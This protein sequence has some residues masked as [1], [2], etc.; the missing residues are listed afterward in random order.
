MKQTDGTFHSADGLTGATGSVPAAKLRRAGLTLTAVLGSLL[1]I[2]VSRTTWRRVE[3]LQG[4]FGGLKADNFYLGVRVRGDIQ[5]LNDTLLRYR[6]RGDTN[7]AAAFRADAQVFKQW[8]EQNRAN[9][10]TPVERKFFDQVTGAYDDYL[11]ESTQV[12]EAS[13]GRMESTKAR[14]FTKSYEKVRNESRGLLNLCDSF[15]GNQRSS[16]TGFLKESSATLTDFKVLLRLLLVLVLA[17]VAALVVLVYGGMIAPLRHQLAETHALIARQEKLASLGVLAAGV[18]HEIRNPLTAIKLRL[19]SLKQHL[20]GAGADDEDAGVI[21]NEITRLERIVQDFL[22]FARPS[23]PQLVATPVQRLFEEVRSLLGVPLKN[24]A[25]ELKVEPAKAAWVRADPQQL[26]QVLINLVQNSADSI[27]RNGVITLRVRNGSGS[28]R[29][30]R[31]QAVILEVADNGK[32]IPPE[33]RKRLFDPFFTTK[34]SGTGLGLPI[35]A[36]IIGKHGG[37]LRYR[38]ELRR[39]TTFSVILP[40]AH[41]QESSDSPDRG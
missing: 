25:I 10:T 17:L 8:L 5:R 24:A 21:G 14:D 4:E 7:D 16:F 33:V 31:G 22:Q 32:G 27:G 29:K 38:T 6:L 26:Q 30:D 37:E 1:V 18:A 28:G 12:L 19:H 15:I 20:P 13:L 39:G 36:R 9:T 35:A 2:W 11:A 41:E 23:E 3:S 40:R 34:E